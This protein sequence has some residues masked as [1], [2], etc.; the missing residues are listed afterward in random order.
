M[1]SHAAALGIDAARIAVCGDSAGGNLAAVVSLLAKRA[2]APKIAFQAL[3][4]PAC[5]GE[6][7]KHP[8]LTQYNKGYLLTE[9]DMQCAP[10]RAALL[11]STRL[12]AK[13]KAKVRGG[14]AERSGAV[15]A[16]GSLS[17]YIC[18]RMMFTTFMALS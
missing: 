15:L 4:Y 2:G 10:A 17:L 11:Q 5:G 8:S 3:I 12:Q 14:L 18:M 9:E 13:M 7:A 16:V 1:A 6:K